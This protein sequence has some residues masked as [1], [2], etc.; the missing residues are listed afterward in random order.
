MHRSVHG[1]SCNSR[2]ESIA[3]HRTRLCRRWCFITV[4]GWAI[5]PDAS[6]SNERRTSASAMI[7]SMLQRSGGVPLRRSGS[8]WGDVDGGGMRVLLSG[9]G[10]GQKVGF[11][12][13]GSAGHPDAA[14]GPPFCPA[15]SRPAGAVRPTSVSGLSTRAR[16][17]G[18]WL[19]STVIGQC[20]PSRPGSFRRL[21]ARNATSTSSMVTG[22]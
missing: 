4:S 8:G 16:T 7:S 3:V 20:S 11:P 14:R 9:S 6:W 19:G 18:S 1:L 17:T 15:A 10:K 2:N 12:R 22:G 5:R 21:A 13:A